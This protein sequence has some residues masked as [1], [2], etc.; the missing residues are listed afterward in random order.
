VGDIGRS[1]RIERPGTPPGHAAPERPREDNPHIK[2]DAPHARRFSEDELAPLS[3][4]LRESLANE[5]VH[6]LVNEALRALPEWWIRLAGVH[7]PE[8]GSPLRYLAIGP[9]GAFIITVTN[10]AWTHDGLLELERAARAVDRRLP[11]HDF[12]KTRLRLVF[13]PTH[14]TLRPQVLGIPGA[15]RI[16]LIRGDELCA[17]L[18]THPG[19]GPC[20]GDLA[21]LRSTL[22]AKLPAAATWVR[23]S[24]FPGGLDSHD[25]SRPAFDD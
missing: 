16:W 14:P 23:P 25:V 9:N 18:L 13:S 11:S 8:L 17:H 10:G 7:L 15:R 20:H 12:S 1:D 6:A 19:A 4:M 24:G 3:D 5:S 22:T 21:A 2:L